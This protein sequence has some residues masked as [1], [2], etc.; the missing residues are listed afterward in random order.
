MHVG[1]QN[2][3]RDTDPG[4]WEI[5]FP[6]DVEGSAL[7]W[8]SIAQDPSIATRA[9]D[10]LTSFLYNMYLVLLFPFYLDTSESIVSF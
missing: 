7:F 5:Q 2:V 3:T 8:Q 6:A 9:Q 4:H 1:L 10:E